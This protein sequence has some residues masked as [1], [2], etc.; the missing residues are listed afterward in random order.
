VVYVAK[1]TI[2]RIRTFQLCVFI[3]LRLDKNG[4]HNCIYF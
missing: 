1:K 4:R 3:D 2:V